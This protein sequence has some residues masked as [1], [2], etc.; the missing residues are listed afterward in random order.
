ADLFDIAGGTMVTGWMKAESQNPQLTAWMQI[1]LGNILGDRVDA[2]PVSGE[3]AQK[4]AFSAV[5]ETGDTITAI[6]LANPGNNVANVSAR[7]YSGGNVAGIREFQ[8]PAYGH[9]VW[10]KNELFRENVP[11]GHVE[12]QSDV[13]LAG[14]Q[15]FSQ[16]DR[17]SA[18]PM[19]PPQGASELV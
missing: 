19:Q 1:S 16:A 14:L 17:W 9:R 7:L 10:L 13:A 11:A 4:M 8:I 15:A 12:I 2:L 5:F 6:G 18:A 3:T